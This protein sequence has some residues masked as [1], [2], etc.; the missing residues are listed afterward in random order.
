MALFGIDHRVIGVDPGTKGGIA[1]LDSE[2]TIRTFALTS[3]EVNDAAAIEFLSGDHSGVVFLEHVHASPIMSRSSAFTFGERFG[4]IK[5]ACRTWGHELRL[6]KPQKWQG[7]MRVK[8]IGGGFGVNDAAKKQASMDR[9]RQ[10]FPD[11]EIETD[12]VADA[13]LLMEFGRLTLER[14]NRANG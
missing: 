12:G 11:L 2:G 9:A 13:L 6:V 1:S 14:E 8:R 7:I 4:F 3:T 5:C 10:L